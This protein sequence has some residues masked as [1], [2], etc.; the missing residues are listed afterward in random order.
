MTELEN[1]LMEML[2]RHGVDA[3]VDVIGAE[4]LI[5]DLAQVFLDAG[6]MRPATLTEYEAMDELNR[7]MG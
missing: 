1:R 3:C 4:R 2:K 5:S 7:R 6:Y